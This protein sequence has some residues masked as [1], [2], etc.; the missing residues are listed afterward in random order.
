MRPIALTMGDPAG[1]GGVLTLRTW[2]AKGGPCLVA[3]DDPERLS[4]EAKSLGLDV[5]VRV[6]DR[7]ADAVAVYAEALPVLP[8]RLT[9]PA[10]PGHPNPA[11]APAVVKSIEQATALCMA[12]E[13][14]AMVTNPIN[15]AALY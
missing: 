1:I 9:E 14:S 15:K 2:L 7:A 6:V 13:A 4:T 10:I 12:G 11:N 3:L 5:P 8:V